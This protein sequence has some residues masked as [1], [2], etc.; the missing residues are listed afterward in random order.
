MAI[1]DKEIFKEGY[2]LLWVYL[3]HSKK[4]KN[5]CIK[6]QDLS[7]EAERIEF[8]LRNGCLLTP[9]YSY[10]F[11]NIYSTTFDEWW[12]EYGDQLYSEY[13]LFPK[14]RSKIIQD[15][16]GKIDW[17][18]GWVLRYFKWKHKRKPNLDEFIS[19]YKGWISRFSSEIFEIDCNFPI[20]NIQK[21]L[22]DFLS[23]KEY[24]KKL[25]ENRKIFDKRYTTKN[26]SLPKT[27]D[28]INKLQKYLMV[29]DLY[30]NKD[31]NNMKWDKIIK[32]VMEKFPEK[33]NKKS[34]ESD[35]ADGEDREIIIKRRF[36]RYNNRAKKII[37]N[38]ENGIFP[39][40][41]K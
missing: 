40:N 19:H 34:N 12:I 28:D 17:H 9:M 29:Y 21:D 6:Y 32:L 5:L 27:K 2:R 14:V 24:Q 25:K 39:G 20:S 33:R 16:K 37:A 18:I 1:I 11:I 13:T 8:A 41:Y 23:N 35:S 15:H 4:Y 30:S 31:K 10:E 26:F 36:Q 3:K 7:D 22:R 38:I